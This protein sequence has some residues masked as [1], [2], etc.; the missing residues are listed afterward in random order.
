MRSIYTKYRSFFCKQYL[1]SFLTTYHALFYYFTH[2]IQNDN[3]NFFKG[4]SNHSLVEKLIPMV[5][6]FYS[7]RTVR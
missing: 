6:K 1:K 4:N 5:K 3:L 7:Q 2:K